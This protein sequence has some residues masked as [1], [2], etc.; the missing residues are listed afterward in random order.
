MILFLVAPE[1]APVGVSSSSITSN[2]LTLT[3]LP[4]E[5]PNGV[6]RYY[7]ISVLE[8]D[9]GTNFTYQAQ[10]TSF[11]IGD[12]HPYYTYLFTVSAVTVAEGPN[13]LGHR[14]TT[15][16]DGTLYFSLCSSPQPSDMTPQTMYKIEMSS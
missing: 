14:V 4:P 8:I 11:S 1:G 3:W 9:T 15:L 6:I 5:N 12:L 13:S 10:S 16:Q 2:S 7:T